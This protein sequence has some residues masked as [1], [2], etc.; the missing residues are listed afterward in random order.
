VSAGT[1][2]S[3]FSFE[4]SGSSGDIWEQRRKAE[5]HPSL[6]SLGG[7][8]RV[9][10]RIHGEG[11]RAWHRAVA[12]GLACNTWGTGLLSAVENQAPLASPHH[13]PVRS[14]DA[15]SNSGSAAAAS[16]S[17]GPGAGALNAGAASAAPTAAGPPSRKG[18]AS[19]VSPREAAIK[20]RGLLPTGRS[21]SERAELLERD[22]AAAAAA[23]PA[24]SAPTS[25]R[26]PG[27]WAK[28]PA[29]GGPTVNR[30]A[31]EIKRAYGRSG[32]SRCAAVRLQ[33]CSLHAAGSTAPRSSRP[34]TL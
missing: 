8:S 17:G 6:A 5:S 2:C 3:V 18:S 26:T 15:A 34:L 29:A 22:A 28:E 16:G 12:E 9:G 30:S 10:G 11:T 7:R 4:T 19:I 24:G 13:L 25:A 1:S 27:G 33:S 32:G 23:A 21:K 31:S 20:L 14:E